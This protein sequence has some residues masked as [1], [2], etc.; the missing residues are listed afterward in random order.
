MTFHAAIFDLDGTLVDSLRDLAETANAVLAE[1]GFPQHPIDAYR[2][3]VGDGVQALISRIV[4]ASTSAEQCRK[5]LEMYTARYAGNWR[6]NSCPYPGVHDMLLALK[7]LGLKMAVLSN[8]PHAF[9]RDFV[10]YFFP[11]QLFD[12]VFGQRPEVERKPSPQGAFEIA[13][14]L[15]VAPARCLFIGDTAIDMKTGR[16]AGMFTIGVLW[17]FRDR[18][19]LEQHRADLIVAHPEEIAEYARR[20]R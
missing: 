18:R 15:G 14:L 7:S 3:F 13:S 8:K 16:S 11:G 5:C 10:E 2:Y 12:G 4:P 9:T 1:S 6:I 19:E 17:G 20:T